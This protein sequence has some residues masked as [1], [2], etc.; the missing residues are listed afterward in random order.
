MA[1]NQRHAQ[2]HAQHGGPAGQL[3]L[4][5]VLRLRQ[6]LAEDDVQHGPRREA[7]RRTQQRPVHGPHGVAQ[8]GPQDGGQAADRRHANGPRRLGPACQQRRGDGHALRDIVQPDDQR[9][10]HAAVPPALGGPGKGGPDGHTHRHIMQRH[11]RRQHQSG[12]VQGVVA[13]GAHLAVVIAQVSRFVVMLMV[14]M[15]VMMIVV[16]MAVPMAVAVVGPLVDP[17]VEQV[18]TEVPHDQPAQD[19]NK[20]AVLHGVGH[21]VKAHHAEDDAGGEAQQQAHRPVRWAVD[22]RRQHAAQGQAAHAGQR[23]DAKNGCI[24]I[25]GEAPV[26][27]V[28]FSFSV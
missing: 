2:Q 28:N 27:N 25:H 5:Q 9:R 18:R 3:V 1:E 21:Q 24:H 8:Q 23:G 26:R 13:A 17:A 19:G 6:Q 22:R 7:Q 15:V 12:G 10:Q 4:P 11:C 16:V 14:V 20:V